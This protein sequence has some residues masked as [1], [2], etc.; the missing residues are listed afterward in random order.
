M[1]ERRL[2]VIAIMTGANAYSEAPQ[3]GRKLMGLLLDR[4]MR[5]LAA[6]AS[7][8]ASFAY[9]R[10]QSV[11]PIRATVHGLELA[12]TPHHPTV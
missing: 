7:E 1:R 6:I 11:N 3:L 12:Y 2:G 9:L 4:K 8:C 5:T 10:R